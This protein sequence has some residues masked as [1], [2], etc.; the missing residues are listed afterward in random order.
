[1]NSFFGLLSAGVLVL[2]LSSCGGGGNNSSGPTVS[3]YN[4]TTLANVGGSITPN[5]V[6]VE[7]GGTTTL[8]LTPD[9]GYTVSEAIGCS[10]SL[11]GLVYTTAPISADCTVSVTFELLTVNIVDTWLVE[12]DS[13]TANLNVTVALS[14]P[15]TAEITLDYATI[16]EVPGNGI[17]DD[18]DGQTDEPIQEGE[19]EPTTDYVPTNGSLA[20]TAGSSQGIFTVSV[21]G[22]LV[23][24]S[25]EEIL[26]EISNVSSNATLGTATGRAV[27]L[28]NETLSNINDTGITACYDETNTIG[29]CPQVGHEGQDGDYGRDVNVNN[30]IDGHAGFSFVKL[31]SNGQPLSIQDASWAPDGNEAAGTQWSCV[32]DRNT[33]I[34][35]EIKADDGGVRDKNWTYILT[36]DADP[37]FAGETLDTA[38]SGAECGGHV[39]DCSVKGYVNTVNALGLCGYNDWI[40]PGEGDLVTL[41]NLSIAA[42]GP[43]VDKRFFPNMLSAS[44]WFGGYPNAAMDFFAY[45]FSNGIDRN[46]D[47]YDPM[48]LY[49]QYYP[50]NNWELLP[51]RLKRRTIQTAL[52]FNDNN[53]GTVTDS[54]TGL[55][56]KQCTVGFATTTTFC[57]TATGDPTL[58]S[59]QTA[60][61]TAESSN[62]AGYN[63][64]RL[65]NHHELAS[66][67]KVG[68]FN[69]DP[70]GHLFTAFPYY[71]LSSS[72]VAGESNL[73]WVMR[74]SVNRSRKAD[75]ITSL[76]TTMEPTRVL[77]VRN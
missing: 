12:G 3:S 18:S 27:I 56:W 23:A 72:T 2:L 70:I 9:S 10:G 75:K 60:L 71:Y 13:G 7:E 66:L 19:A 25:D 43:T 42:P 55:M 20:I 16:G 53:D 17:D 65:P 61:A 38:T 47:P 74:N 34:T 52:R 30:D 4:V 21:L 22:D 40:A 67:F 62:F 15:S 59:W 41:A 36:F 54:H 49:G 68:V 31:D 8:T 45:D 29:T 6:I 69:I 33:G 26:I 1:M 28:N 37:I 64:W 77:L 24:E 63:D 73:V 48:V 51:I 76:T 39:S 46:A 14:G 32:L 57:D 58:M 50:D 35:W 11:S 5:T 44:Y